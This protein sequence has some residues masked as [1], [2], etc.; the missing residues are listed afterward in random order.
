[1]V[2]LVKFETNYAL[3]FKSIVDI[4]L[5]NNWKEKNTTIRTIKM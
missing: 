3:M 1:M 2:M 5:I 4:D